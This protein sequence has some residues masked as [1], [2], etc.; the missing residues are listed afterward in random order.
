MTAEA[1]VGPAHPDR[2][3]N[4]IRHRIRFR[5]EL[6]GAAETLARKDRELRALLEESKVHVRR[7]DTVLNAVAVGVL[8]TN[9][10]GRTS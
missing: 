5:V 10:A 9:P 1:L 2:E 6:D 8:V 3:P 7:L 4:G